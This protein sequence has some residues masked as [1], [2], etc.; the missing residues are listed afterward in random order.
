MEFIS[1]ETSVTNEDW[2]EAQADNKQR[3]LG[4]E[5]INLTIEQN[6]IFKKA[7]QNEYR[8]KS[9]KNYHGKGLFKVWFALEDNPL[10]FMLH[11]VKM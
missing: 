8:E 9:F 11:S 10:P 1:S 5:T 3:N 7:N 2:A 4:L 6:L